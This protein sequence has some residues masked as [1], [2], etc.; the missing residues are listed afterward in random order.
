[1][2]SASLLLLLPYTPCLLLCFSWYDRLHLSRTVHQ[3]KPYFLQ[4]DFVGVLVIATRNGAKTMRKYYMNLTLVISMNFL[5]CPKWS[6]TTHFNWLRSGNSWILA[7]H[8]SC[9]PGTPGTAAPSC[10]S[11]EVISLGIVKY[12]WRNENIASFTPWLVL[13]ISPAA[14]AWQEKWIWMKSETTRWGWTTFSHFTDYILCGSKTYKLQGK[15]ITSWNKSLKLVCI[16][17]ICVYSGYTSC[18]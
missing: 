7:D 16:Y 6:Y 13:S 1:M 3:N 14:T 11:N 10:L 17:F 2:G 8:P 12:H 4:V 18:T 5:L 15:L 9:S